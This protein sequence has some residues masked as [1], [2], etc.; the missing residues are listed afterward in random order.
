MPLPHFKR[1]VIAASLGLATALSVNAA[2]NPGIQYFIDGYPIERSWVLGD[3]GNWSVPV[4]DLTGRS[5]GGK[6]E[7]SPAVAADG[8]PAMRAKFTRKKLQ[9]QLSL[10]G[11]SI[12]ISGVRDLVA[13]TVDMRILKRPKGNLYIG[14]DC[15]WPCRAQVPIHDVV[16]EYPANEWFILPIPL[17]CFKSDNFDLSKV[18]GPFLLL[19]SGQVEL[20][21]GDIRLER[22]PPDMPH[23][24]D[25]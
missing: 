6:I 5:A 14:I 17:N 24:G 4:K 11:N 20:E 25:K 15:T 13:L 8:K 18:N 7:V 9:G 21:L 1:A 3:P 16:K 12:D 2:P 10:Y 22:M 23:C 19:S